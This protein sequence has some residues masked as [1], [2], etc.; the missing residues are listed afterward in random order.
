MRT[1]TTATTAAPASHTT[2]QVAGRP[3]PARTALLPGC[4]VARCT[5]LALVAVTGS[6]PANVLVV[7]LAAAM[8]PATTTEDVSDQPFNILRT[9]LLSFAVKCDGVMPKHCQIV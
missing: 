5:I 7:H 3:H 8:T 1:A 9:P 6:T 2:T 4:V